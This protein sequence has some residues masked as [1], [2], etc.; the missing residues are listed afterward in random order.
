[1]S[2]LLCRKLHRLCNLQKDKVNIRSFLS[3]TWCSG[4]SASLLRL[5]LSA[6]LHLDVQIH[7]GRTGLEFP[8]ELLVRSKLKVAGLDGETDTAGSKKI[9][10]PHAGAQ[11]VYSQWLPT[12][13]WFIYGSSLLDALSQPEIFKYY[14]RG[15]S[16]LDPT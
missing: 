14:R 2:P 10:L 1:M 13:G 6:Q 4:C 12:G 9:C 15:G 3:L 16:A 5:F 7:L 8:T 11:L